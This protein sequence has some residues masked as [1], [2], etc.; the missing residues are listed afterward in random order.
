MYLCTIVLASMFYRFV[1][2]P[3]HIALQSCRCLSR[4]WRRNHAMELSQKERVC[5]RECRLRE[6]FVWLEEHF[7]STFDGIRE[8]SVNHG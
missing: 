1:G 6:C 8:P 5:R 3:Y 2:L 7:K 4:H